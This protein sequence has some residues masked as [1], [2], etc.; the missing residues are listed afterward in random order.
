MREALEGAWPTGVP[1]KGVLALLSAQ[2]MPNTLLSARD[3]HLV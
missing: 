3:V 1:R 2:D